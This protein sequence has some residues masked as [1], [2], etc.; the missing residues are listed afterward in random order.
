[1]DATHLADVGCESAHRTSRAR[2]C[3]RLRSRERDGIATANR[4]AR[5]HVSIDPDIRMIV[6]RRG[7][8]D[9][10]ILRISALRPSPWQHSAVVSYE[11]FAD[12][13]RNALEIGALS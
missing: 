10:G 6:L 11:S 3:T 4:A 12:H 2:F 5:D 1:M 9:P 13:D 7:T 8:Q